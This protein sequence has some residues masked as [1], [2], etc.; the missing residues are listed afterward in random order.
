MIKMEIT[1]NSISF[2]QG[3]SRVDAMIARE[4]TGIHILFKGISIS[5]WDIISE[6]TN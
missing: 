5:L 3:E 4:E 2:F 1:N 6:L